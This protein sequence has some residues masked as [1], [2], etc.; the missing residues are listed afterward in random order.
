M[1]DADCP[2]L[3][4]VGAVRMSADFDAGAVF[5]ADAAVDY[6]VGAAGGVGAEGALLFSFLCWLA[7]LCLLRR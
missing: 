5:D 1:F 3:S 7:L 6:V 4:L 2:V